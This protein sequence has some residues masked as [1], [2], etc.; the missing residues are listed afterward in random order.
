LQ[1]VLGKQL[2]RQDARHKDAL[3]KKK[4]ALALFEEALALG[5]IEAIGLVGFALLVGKDEGAVKDN[6]RGFQ[7]SLHLSALCIFAV[8][9]PGLSAVL[10]SAKNSRICFAP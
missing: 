4:Q 2:S 3:G 9:I 1:I 10:I 6:I 5:S 7:V 8:L